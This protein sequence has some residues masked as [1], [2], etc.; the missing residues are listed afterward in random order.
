M[1]KWVIEFTK[2]SVKQF[3]QLPI[4]LQFKVRVLVDEMRI[5]GPVRGNWK[6]YSKLGFTKHHCHLSG[7]RPTYVMCWEVKDNLNKKIEV[8]YVGS[9]EKAPY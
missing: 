8:Y 5:N 6:N 1:N 9:H 4:R 7:G 3:Q 2:H